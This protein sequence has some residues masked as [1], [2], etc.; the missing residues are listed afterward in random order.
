MQ[1]IFALAVLAS[2]GIANDRPIRPFS[3]FRPFLAILTLLAASVMAGC[4]AR[5]SASPPSAGASVTNYEGRGVVARLEPDGRTVVIRHE[6]IP[7]YMGAMT[8]PFLARDPKIIA[9]IKAGNL[10][11]FRLAVTADDGWIESIRILQTNAPPE[12]RPASPV[13]REIEPL[14]EGGLLPEYRFTN[15]LGRA[16]SLSDYRGGVAA[17]TF[18]FTRCPYPLFCPKMSSNF[19]EAEQLL[20]NDPDAPKQWRLFSI[21]FDPESDS[22]PVL[23]SYALRYNYDAAHWSFLT[24]DL[25]DINAIGAQ[26]GFGFWR[27]AGSISHNLRTVVLDPRG[28]VFKIMPGNEWT[29]RMLADAMKEAAKPPAK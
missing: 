28:R 2:F 6:A 22:P 23:K 1:R 26:F 8:M 13:A 7:G 17:F 9:G 12:E 20:K 29:A 16:V 5:E 27:E 14:A 21:S 3:P 10:V 15:E 18:L 11:A 4:R 24:G 25:A 19:Q